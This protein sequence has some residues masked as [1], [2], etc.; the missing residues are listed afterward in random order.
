MIFALGTYCL[1]TNVVYINYERGF[2]V[3]TVISKHFSFPFLKGEVNLRVAGAAQLILV[4][5]ARC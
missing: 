5:F 4:G 2:A 3:P 1:C